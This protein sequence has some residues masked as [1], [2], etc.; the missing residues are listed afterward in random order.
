VIAI[1][2]YTYGVPTLEFVVQ[3]TPM[4]AQASS[5]AKR[6]WQER[7]R[8]NANA[9]AAALQWSPVDGAVLRVAYFYIDAPAADLDNIVKP[10]QDALK[11]I[12]YEDDIQ[13]ID[14]IASMRSKDGSG[15]IPMSAVLARGFGGNS[16][17]V[18][19]TV[20]GSSAI[21]VLR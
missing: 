10:I 11:G 1:T 13:V 15:V 16:D 17:F 14:L 19:V 7:V 3:G 9:A 8:R 4:S 12:A 5:D 20:Q 18:Y 2:R 6:F 21:E